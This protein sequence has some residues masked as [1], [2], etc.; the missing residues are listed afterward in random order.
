MHTFVYLF[1]LVRMV[2][3]D[4]RSISKLGRRQVRE[5]W[6]WFSPSTRSCEKHGTQVFYF[7]CLK[8]VPFGAVCY[9]ESDC[10][11]LVKFK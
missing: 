9:A 11:Q 10:I 6:A 8:R 5:S 4:C 7:S 1:M 2:Y 3:H